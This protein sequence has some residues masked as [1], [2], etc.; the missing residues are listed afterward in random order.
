MIKYNLMHVTVVKSLLECTVGE[1]RDTVSLISTF[2]PSLESLNLVFPLMLSPSNIIMA[3]FF[4]SCLSFCCR[5]P[6]R[7]VFQVARDWQKQLLQME[8]STKQ[9]H[10]HLSN[11]SMSILCAV[12]RPNRTVLSLLECPFCVEGVR[13][14]TVLQTQ[15]LTY[16]L[17]WQ[18]QNTR[19]LQRS[20]ED[21]EV[22]AGIYSVWRIIAGTMPDG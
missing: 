1:G 11:D 9:K 7:M 17:V 15:E 16:P 3:L 12:L 2:W 5:P 18:R 19:K 10:D 8:K 13:F 4:V 21:S 6:S 20:I 14:G 22:A